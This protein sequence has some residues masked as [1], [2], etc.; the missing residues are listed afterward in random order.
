MLAFRKTIL[1]EKEGKRREQCQSVFS[2]LEAIQASSCTMTC[3]KEFECFS[4]TEDPCVP[5]SEMSGHKNG[6]YSIRMQEDYRAP[7][8]YQPWPSGEWWLKLSFFF[9]GIGC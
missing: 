4:V 9:L 1:C 7:Y 6:L 2:E 5:G 3:R 8:A